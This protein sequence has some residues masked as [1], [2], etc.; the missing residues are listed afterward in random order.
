MMCQSINNL[1]L[2][3]FFSFMI[4]LFILVSSRFSFAGNSINLKQ[5]YDIIENGTEI[6]N[7]DVS[8]YTYNKIGNYTQFTDFNGLVNILNN[9]NYA[10]YIQVGDENF[11]NQDT[12]F[13][14]YYNTSWSGS[15]P[16]NLGKSGF[17]FSNNNLIIGGWIN[18]TTAS[19]IYIWRATFN[20]TN[21]TC[22]I[23]A[24][25]TT[26]YTISYLNYNNF[27]VTLEQFKSDDFQR[28]QYWNM[29]IYSTAE[30]YSSN[31]TIINNTWNGQ[32][33]SENANDGGLVEYSVSDNLF[34][35][36]FVN[37][38]NISGDFTNKIYLQTL[39]SDQITSPDNKFGPLENDNIKLLKEN[40]FTNVSLFSNDINLND[41]AGLNKNYI[42]RVVFK[43]YDGTRLAQEGYSQFFSLQKYYIPGIIIEDVSS[44]YTNTSGESTSVDTSSG[45]DK[46][47]L[48]GI[49]GGIS[50]LKDDLV[51]S[52][53]GIENTG[54]V[55]KILRGLLSLFVPDEEFFNEYWESL[56]VF[57][58]D[59]L[60]FLW[61]V[62]VFIP[63]LIDNFKQTVSAYNKETVFTIPAISIPTF[64][65]DNSEVVILESFEWKPYAFIGG[66]DV[67]LSIYKLY[68]DLVDFLVFWA[69][70]NQLVSVLKSILGMAEEDEEDTKGK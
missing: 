32:F 13:T 41:I 2:K 53:D 39:N 5:F 40:T 47:D 69:L 1:K 27:D 15:V 12:C 8:D 19:P 57:F 35:Y 21:K 55:G 38:G 51:G 52:G 14:L 48:S 65:G 11:E 7:L 42:Y 26:G 9:S 49:I 24:S 68:L 30:F 20:T 16:D 37:N 17:K 31:G 54:L 3:V 64:M 18:S 63:N 43:T 46:T 67:F 60:G 34:L 50:D 4:V 28:I 23:Y 29:F 10:K 61:D 58:S 62:I 6:K 25:K 45:D 44:V 33:I 66:N 59:K 70:M 56:R 22:N 36:N